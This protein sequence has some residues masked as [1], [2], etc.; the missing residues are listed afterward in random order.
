MQFF[1]IIFIILF[2]SREF[3]IGTDTEAYVSSYLK[4][5]KFNNIDSAKDFGYVIYVYFLNIIND[6]P[7]FF[8]Y[9]FALTFMAFVYK[10]FRCLDVKNKFIFFFCFTS[11]FFFKAFGINILRQGVAISI[12]VYVLSNSSLNNLK[13]VGLI[14]IAIS[15]HFSVI[16]LLFAYLIDLKSKS[17]KIGIAFISLA[18]LAMVL[19]FD[20]YSLAKQIPLLGNVIELR[21]SKYALNEFNTDYK[22]G[23]R[24]DFFLFNIS[25]AVVGLLFYRKFKNF[26][27]GYKSI[28]NIYLITSGFFILMFK[29]PFSDRFGLLSWVLIPLLL[30]P[31]D[32]KYQKFRYGRINVVLISILVFFIFI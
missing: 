22:T 8:L 17:V 3:S 4:Y 2:G 27:P 14:L 6:S 25:F 5:S 24:L 32:S 9:A 21:F 31:L 30:M 16:V 28:L 7:R 19:N 26:I 11:F 23:F 1:T 13:K 18:S 20:F 15:F 29:I 10:S 12:F